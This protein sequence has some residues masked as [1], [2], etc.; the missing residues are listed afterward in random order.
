M[1]SSTF[2][3]DGFGNIYIPDG[4]MLS[5]SVESMLIFLYNGDQWKNENHGGVK[6]SEIH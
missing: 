6:F 2:H 3:D 1:N 5:R 4:E